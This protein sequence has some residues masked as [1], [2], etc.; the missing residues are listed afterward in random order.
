MT[1]KRDPND[2][3]LLTSHAPDS[4]ALDWTITAVEAGISGAAGFIPGVG[5]LLSAAAVLFAKGL[6]APLERRERAYVESIAVGVE[7]LRGQ[8]ANIEER[9]SSDAF[10]TAFLHAGHISMRTHQ[11][12]KR[13]ALRNAVLNVAAGAAPDDDLQIV[14]LSFIDQF[15]PWHLRLLTYLD[16]PVAWMEQHGVPIPP[17]PHLDGITLVDYAFPELNVRRSSTIAFLDQLATQ[18]LLRGDWNKQATYRGSPG[19][20]GVSR[21]SDLGKQFLA[22]IASPVAEHEADEG[23]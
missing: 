12:D 6:R 9:V 17:N 4:A 15:T 21:I 18:G 10:L 23:D 14:F 22:F 11:P 3:D 16:A 7:A 20:P 19:T 13:K 5:G 8:V 1:D 2:D